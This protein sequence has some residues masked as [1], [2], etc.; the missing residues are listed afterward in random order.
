MSLVYKAAFELTQIR[1][2]YNIGRP[3]S[4]GGKV[5]GT[6]EAVRAE[7]QDVFEKVRGKEGEDVR[8]GMEKLSKLV[9]ASREVGESDKA[10][11]ALGGV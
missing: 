11:I 5:E 10:M 2:G 7:L 3:L 1:T 4:R 8:K 9:R 6:D